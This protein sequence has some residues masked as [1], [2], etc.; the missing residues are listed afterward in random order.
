[1]KLLSLNSSLSAVTLRQ[2]QKLRGAKPAELP[3]KCELVI[4]LKTAEHSA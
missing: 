4:N 2:S 3:T 1:M